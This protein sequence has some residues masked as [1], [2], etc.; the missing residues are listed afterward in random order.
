MKPII[1]DAS[2]AIKWFIP[3]DGSDAATRLFSKKYQMFAPDLIRPEV[4]NVIWKLYKRRLIDIDT[5]YQVMDDFLSM[6]IDIC[7]NQP[8]IVSALEIAAETKITVYDSLYVALAAKIG[9]MMITADMR[10]LNSLDSTAYKP[11]IKLLG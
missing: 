3:E 4:G 9:G 6:P 8:L 7:D 1:I 2:V 10:L 11:F 5:A